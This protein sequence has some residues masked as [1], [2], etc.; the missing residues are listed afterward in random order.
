MAEE[1]RF[2]IVEHTADQ[3]LRAYGRDLRELME[4]AAAGMLALL[5]VEAPPPSQDTLELQ[6]EAGSPELVVQHALR[7]LLYLLEDEGLAPVSVA[8]PQASDHAAALRVGVVD[9]ELAEPLFGALMKAVTR[10]GL[11]IETVAGRLSLVLVF[12]V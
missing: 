11:Q 1:P 4:N 2:E 3:A 9:R 10:H 7:E 5:Y 6:V 12:D 8:V